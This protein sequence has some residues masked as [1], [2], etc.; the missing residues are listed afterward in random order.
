M[1]WLIFVLTT[2]FTDYTDNKLLKNMTEKA[3]R[4]LLQLINRTVKARSD[5]A[6]RNYGTFYQNNPFIPQ[7]KAV[8]SS[9]IKP[10]HEVVLRTLIQRAHVAQGLR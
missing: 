10:R 8:L 6:S 1:T 4:E 9:P 2:D 7:E 3:L 5:E